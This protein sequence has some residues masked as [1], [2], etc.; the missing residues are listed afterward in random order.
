MRT[1]MIGAAVAGL[2]GW[3]LALH[4]WAG[5]PAELI[6]VA[7]SQLLVLLMFARLARREERR[8]EEQRREAERRARRGPPPTPR[9]RDLTELRDLLRDAGRRRSDAARDALY[10]Q[11]RAYVRDAAEGRPLDFPDPAE[12]R[13]GLLHDRARH[14]SAPSGRTFVVVPREADP[15]WLRCNRP[16]EAM[17]YARRVHPDGF[18]IALWIKPLPRGVRLVDLIG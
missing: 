15:Y 2:L 13:G 1:P 14:A 5:A 8:R 7:A 6:V 4:R 16:V 10:D 12:L 17:K 9:D 18:E 11:V 3:G